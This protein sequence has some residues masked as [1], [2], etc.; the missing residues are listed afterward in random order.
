MNHAIRLRLLLFVVFLCLSILGSLQAQNFEGVIEMRQETAEG[1]SYTLKWYIKGDRLAYELT[2][3]GAQM[4][5]VP[6]VK[7]GKMLMVTGENKTIIPVSE[8]TG[9]AVAQLRGATFQNNGQGRCPYFQQVQQWRMATSEVESVLDVTTDVAISFAEYRD[10]FKNDY[11]LC[12][13]AASGKA[14]FPL[15]SV[16]RD[17]TGK[18]LSRTTIIKVTRMTVADGYFE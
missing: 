1:L 12:A 9:N 10:F 2:D 8:I 3:R 16:T 14:G 11:S 4:R 18:V 7:E 17:K 6:L 13:L 15:N 5:F